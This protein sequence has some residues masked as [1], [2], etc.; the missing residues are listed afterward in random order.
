MIGGV[1]LMVGR[2]PRSKWSYGFYSLCDLFFPGVGF[3]SFYIP[4][5]ELHAADQEYGKQGQ[6]GERGQRE[7]S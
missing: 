1:R 5:S 4:G 7:E 2:Q 6:N 3:P